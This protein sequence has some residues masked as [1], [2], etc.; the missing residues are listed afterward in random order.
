[1]NTFR[2]LREGERGEKLLKAGHEQCQMEQFKKKGA[3][4]KNEN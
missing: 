3:S 4:E 1:M 2:I